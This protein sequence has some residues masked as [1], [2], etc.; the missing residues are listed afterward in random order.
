MGGGGVGALK[1]SSLLLGEDEGVGKEEGGPRV[2]WDQ[3]WGTLG[4]KET[5]IVFSA[6]FCLSFPLLEAQHASPEG[7]GWDVDVLKLFP[8]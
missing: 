2:V 6:L 4:G 8:C 3:G 1:L 5:H 7:R